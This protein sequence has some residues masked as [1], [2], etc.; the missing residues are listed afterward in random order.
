MEVYVEL[1]QVVLTILPEEGQ[2]REIY[3]NAN[4]YL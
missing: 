4:I 1:L 2:K 3:K